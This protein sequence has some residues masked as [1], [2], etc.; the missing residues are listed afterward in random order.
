MMKQARW[1]ALVAA[2]FG[3]ALL[4]GCGGGGSSGT[5]TTT[6]PGGGGATNV[7]FATDF[8]GDI[9]AFPT[10]TP[11]GASFTGQV[12]ASTSTQGS[13][14]AYDAARDELYSQ[15]S[16]FVG[17]SFHAGVEVFAH[18]STM[19]AGASPARSVTL[20][21]MNSA[22]QILLETGSDT[23]WVNG[24]DAN[25]T[26]MVA[27]FDHASTLSGTVSPSRKVGVSAFDIAVD[28][29][30]SLLYA[31]DEFGT[32]SVFAD[33]AT[34][35]GQPMPTRTF[36]V[37]EG[38]G[39][40]T[41]DGTRDIAY[42]SSFSTAKIYIVHGASSASGLVPLIEIAFPVPSSSGIATLKV[43][44]LHDRLYVSV[45]QS[46]YLFENASTLTA[47]S[48]VPVASV[49]LPGIAVDSYAFP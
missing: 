3:A 39:H 37:P 45:G 2:A 6:G 9:A 14:L 24:S 22:E 40:L 35:D 34:L 23:L 11:T 33:A 1:A 49:S 43:D 32:V 47:G 15:V 5:Q 16:T 38:A 18:A 26:S 17:G 42:V 8:E 41:V 20:A 46:V 28:A 27:V 4:P 10:L 31:A 29:G 48:S 7:L 19:Q 12:V 36:G 44:P 30:R 25:S 13:S 21:G